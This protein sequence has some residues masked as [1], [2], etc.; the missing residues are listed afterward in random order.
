VGGDG[1]IGSLEFVSAPLPVIETL[2]ALI[3]DGVLARHERLRFGLIEFGSTW[4]PGY[5]HYLDSAMEAFSRTET[6][7][8]K[9]DLGLSEYV[10][11]QVRVA[12]F[13]HENAGWLMS[14]VGDEM[15]MFSSDYPH[16]EG[17]RNPVARFE[18][19]MDAYDIPD[20]ARQ[21]FYTDNFVDLMGGHVTGA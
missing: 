2:T 1:P 16:I 7:L 20:R 19:S 17:G 12:P 9:L 14:Q 10:S 15:C 3:V 5:M 13:C 6:R 11:R 4:L 8:Q 21:R 18:R